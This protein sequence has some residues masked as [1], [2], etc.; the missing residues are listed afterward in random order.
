MIISLAATMF[1]SAAG[2]ALAAEP[3]GA[4]EVNIGFHD[5]AA[6]RWW[7]DETSYIG[8][9]LYV[10][11]MDGET[12][13]G[14]W[15]YLIKDGKRLASG[16]GSIP[17]SDVHMNGFGKAV[18]DTDTRDNDAFQV[19]GEEY[20]PRGEIHIE[21]KKLKGGVDMES[22]HIMSVEPGVIV[23]NLVANQPNAVLSETEGTLA[24]YEISNVFVSVTYHYKYLEHKITPGGD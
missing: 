6:V 13:A 16:T 14:L 17:V 20:I 3:G 10:H 8:L 18:L 11:N 1:I 23:D 2:T 22:F 4:A 24:G 5:Q 19:T 15:Y 21:W 12:T 7:V 9:N